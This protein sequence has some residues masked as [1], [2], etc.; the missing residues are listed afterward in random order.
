MALNSNTKRTIAFLLSI[1]MVISVFFAAMPLTLVYATD[2]ESVTTEGDLTEIADTDQIIEDG[3]KSVDGNVV[4]TTETES[5]DEVSMAKEEEGFSEVSEEGGSTET[6]TFLAN[7]DNEQ[8]TQAVVQGCMSLMGAPIVPLGADDTAQLTGEN[9]NASA[10]DKDV[11]MEISIA[12]CPVFFGMVL[13]IKYDYSTLTLKAINQGPATSMTN[14]ANFTGNIK[15]VDE[16]FGRVLIYGILQ[17]PQNET[18]FTTAQDDVLFTLVFDVSEPAFSGEYDV[19]IEVDEGEGWQ[20]T[21][22]DNGE[23][24]MD[25]GENGV[26][27][28]ITVSGE[29]GEALYDGRGYAT[30]ENAIVATTQSGNHGTIKMLKDK[31][32]STFA[33]RIV[34]PSGANITLD[35]NGH[36]VTSSVPVPQYYDPVWTVE[37]EDGAELNLVSTGGTRGTFEHAFCPEGSVFLLNA[38]TLNMSEVDVANFNYGVFDGSKSSSESELAGTYGTFE[39]CDFTTQHRAFYFGDGSV[40]AIKGCEIKVIGPPADAQSPDWLGANMAFMIN[41]HLDLLEGCYIECNADQTLQ[42]AGRIETIKDC[43]I[44]NNEVAG[45]K[46]PTALYITPGSSIDPGFR[47]GSII[48]TEIV[49]MVDCL[50]TIDLITG[51]D[52]SFTLPTDATSWNWHNIRVGGNVV[53]GGSIGAIEG[54]VFRNAQIS[55][56]VGA[57]GEIGAISGGDFEIKAGDA[58]YPIWNNGFIGTING[59]F[60]NGGTKTAFMNQGQIRELSGG[61]FISNGGAAFTNGERG[62]IDTISGGT[63]IGKT[64]GLRNNKGT[65][66][67]ITKTVGSEPVFVANKS[68]EAGG[69]ALA[70]DGTTEVSAKVNSVTAGYYKAKQYDKL[71]KQYGYATITIP[72]G[73]GFGTQ[74]MRPEDFDGEEGFYHFGQTVDITWAVAGKGDVID[75]FVSGD[76]VYYNYAEPTSEAGI[77]AGWKDEEG[78]L[79]AALPRAAANATYTAAFTPFAPPAEDYQISLLSA[80]DGVY[81]GQE[82]GVLVQLSSNH[83]DDFYGATVKVNYDNTKVTYH[84]YKSNIGDSLVVK[85]SSVDDQLEII[86]ACE[87]GYVI[88]KGVLG[89]VA[90]KFK[91]KSNVAVSEDAVFGV[92]EGPIVNQSGNPVDVEVDTGPD[93]TV[94]INS[95]TVSFNTD[96]GSTVDPQSPDYGGLAV[97]P[98]T[99]PT[100]EGYFFEGW[101]ADAKCTLAFNF[102]AAITGDTV[103]YAGWTINT[104]TLTYNAGLNGS[105]EGTSPQV[106]NHGSSGSAVTAVADTG[107]HFVEWSDDSTQNP[108]TDVGVTADITVTATFTLNKYTVKFIDHDG[109]II[110]SILVDHG[111][112]ATGPSDPSRTGWSLDNW[113]VDETCEDVFDFN[114]QITAD[115][116]IYAGYSINQYTISFN[117]DGG[118]VVASIKQ[119]YDTAII[120][121]SD[122][123][124]YGYDFVGW[125]PALPATMPAEDLQL[126]AQWEIKK[127]ALIF[128]AGANVNMD[129]FVAYVKHG[130]PGLYSDSECTDLLINEPA[131]EP[132][133]HHTLDTPLWK[134]VGVIPETRCGFSQISENTYTGAMTYEATASANEY[135]VDYSA[136]CVDIQSGVVSGK[137]TYG[138]DVEFKAKAKS[139]HVVQSVTYKVE[140]GEPVTLVADEGVYTIAGSLVIGDI[141][142]EV[143]YAVDGTIS[144]ISNDNYN[145]LPTGHKLLVLTVDAKLT[146]GAYEY[147][148]DAMF[149]SSKYGEEGEYVYLFIVPIDDADVLGKIEIKEGA[150][151][152]K[153]AYDGDINGNG[154][155][156]STDILAA[157]DLYKQHTN[158]KTDISFELLS[159]RARLEADV[160]GDGSVDTQ[161][162]QEIFNLWKSRS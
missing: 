67:N 54:G 123:T 115:T 154:I 18:L 112:T 111:G 118:T 4:M 105:I 93:V 124:K 20:F 37:V 9:I 102:A 28:T 155:V 30:L 153:L 19:A 25:I 62:T 134:V 81:Q 56:Y 8:E 59:G 133:A 50:G 24:P 3:D 137:A 82:F 40:E 36:T 125:S 76:P 136:D 5:E 159:I 49:G 95:I 35:M 71:V 77:F 26:V 61:E 70:A 89:L 90:L 27:G 14:G 84:G 11:S 160:N 161:D 53:C 132:Y 12:N 13:N 2:I 116:N 96:G 101:Y 68:E 41:D 104:Y 106:V 98:A 64:Y 107:Y 149:Y 143:T 55:V 138:V 44:V 151:N 79:H 144:F 7:V 52:T 48:D 113:Y 121:P 157:Y 75:K 73:Y 103:I 17:D 23:L 60:F 129:D 29:E 110:E 114:T 88:D 34:I 158:Y 142:I 94:T 141:E 43:K 72:N 145:G 83:N 99:N 51:E 131:L 120:A 147:D 91:A 97:E 39:N 130:I 80:L 109:S 1:V 65:I 21:D 128:K 87:N 22:P 69:D 78:N 127:Y 33:K 32:V 16:D 100:K 146:G 74:P 148:G 117:S 85:K 6:D 66:G 42:V 140:S 119:D 108:R 38:G 86:C 156:N 135:N 58:Y 122:P 152:E 45:D 63:F 150:V 162:A 92:V 15:V 57:E 46:T 126:T 139:N 10:G 31:T 47:I